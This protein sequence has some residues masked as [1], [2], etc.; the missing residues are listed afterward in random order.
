MTIA[1]SPSRVYLVTGR[2]GM[3]CFYGNGFS[4]DSLRELAFRQYDILGPDVPQEL[5]SPAAHPLIA[6]S[7]GEIAASLS[8]NVEKWVHIRCHSGDIATIPDG[9]DGVGIYFG[10]SEEQRK[11]SHGKT[12]EYIINSARETINTLKAS[13]YAVRF[14][15]EDIEVTEKYFCTKERIEKCKAGGYCQ[16]GVLAETLTEFREQGIPQQLKEREELNYDFSGN[17]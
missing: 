9:I 7:I 10:T 16:L 15:A 1:V 13:G 2:E 3:Q 6:R 17:A 12:I 4:H 8:N 14:T 5:G 11:H